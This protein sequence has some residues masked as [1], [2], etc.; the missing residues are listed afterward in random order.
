MSNL[1]CPKAVSVQTEGCLGLIFWNIMNFVISKGQ[2]RAARE[3]LLSRRSLGQ[4]VGAAGEQL[5]L[6]LLKTSPKVSWLP[7]SAGNIWKG[8]QSLASLSSA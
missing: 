7:P 1:S 6:Q 4:A 8:E 2:S 5:N 3:M